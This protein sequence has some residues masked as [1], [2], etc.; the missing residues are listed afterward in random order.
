[1][2]G[3]K[4]FDAHMHIPTYGPTMPEKKNKLLLEMQTNG[5]AEGIVISD[6]TMTSEIGTL[7]D[8]LD[9]FYDI[10][11][12]HIVGGISIYHNYQEQLRLLES[13]LAERK[14]VG[15]KLFCGHE[16]F[17]ITDRKLQPVYGL[18]EKYHV[19]ILFHSEGENSKYAY[20]DSTYNAVL[21]HPEITFVC[22]HCHYPNVKECFQ[23]Y[24]NISNIVYDMS[25]IVDMGISPGIKEAIENQLNKFP[26][27]IMFGSDY[28]S[29]SQSEHLKF[30]MSLDIDDVIRRKLLYETA[31]SVYF[32]R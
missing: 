18:A 1:M 25:S 10:S 13:V 15:V 23:Q 29:C 28:A 19:P 5:I 7:Q 24:K 21:Q 30:A 6:S 2:S 27:S 16:A 14:I 20:Y 31:Y 22:C 32:L 17:Y 26:D 9:L 8:C 4:I 12:I 3:F 11:K